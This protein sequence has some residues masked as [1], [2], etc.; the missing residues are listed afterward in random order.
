[1]NEQKANK[2]LI[3]III[4][5]VAA[6]VLIASGITA[7]AII[8]K[9]RTQVIVEE[10]TDDSTT[11]ML[12]TEE[13]STSDEPILEETTQ[14]PTTE[15]AVKPIGES[16]GDIV[17]EYEQKYGY[18]SKTNPYVTGVCY[19]NLLDFDAD[20]VDELLILYNTDSNSDEKFY[21]DIFTYTDQ[22]A[23]KIASKKL[24]CVTYDTMQNICYYEEYDTNK[25][26]IYDVDD[27]D[28]EE[29]YGSLWTKEGNSFNEAHSLNLTDGFYRLDGDYYAQNDFEED[30]F[31]VSW[32]DIGT[33]ETEEDLAFTRKCISKMD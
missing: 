33:D 21:Y 3:I 9:H 8:Y 11:T 1:M 27:F 18:F 31:A 29:T 10:I 14:E 17:D 24:N 22:G 6:V 4:A 26:Y 2:K 5:V 19:L 23:E 30:M 20:G 25:V 13:D 16:Y 15:V 28:A 12:S 7:A 32:L